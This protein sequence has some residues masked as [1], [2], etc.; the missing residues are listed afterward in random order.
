L[1]QITSNAGIDEKAIEI[2][3]ADFVTGSLR[4]KSFARPNKIFT[5]HESLINRRVAI[6]RDQTASEIEAVVALLRQK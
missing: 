4:Q 2:K 6:L 3:D 5:G 1:C